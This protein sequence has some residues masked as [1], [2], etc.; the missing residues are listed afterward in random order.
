MQ[1]R[2]AER[3]AIVFDEA[4]AF[5]MTFNGDR[6]ARRV[7]AH[8][9]DPDRATARTDIPQQF[10]WRR[11]KSRKRD[12]A[13]I[14]LGQ[15]AVVAKRVVGQTR[16]KRQPRRA[17]SGTA[18]QRNQVQCRHRFARPRVGAATETAFPLAAEVLQH[19]H[20]GRAEAA[21]S[22]QCSQCSGGGAIGAQD[23]EP[24]ASVQMDVQRGKRPTHQRDHRHILQR[25]PEARRRQRQRRRCGQ[26]AH[27]TGRQL[28]GKCRPHAEQHRI[29]ACEHANRRVALG[30]HRGD[31][32][33]TRPCF[34]PRRETRG[35]HRQMPLA[36]EYHG[37]VEQ[38]APCRAPQTGKAV[39]A[40]AHHGQPCRHESIL[41]LDLKL[42]AAARQSRPQ[43]RCAIRKKA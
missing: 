3:V 39:I 9:F 14:A 8:P 41:I 38:R 12:G 19:D 20:A 4:L 16:R 30:Q 25:P 36:A 6:P 23:E 28:T 15:L 22:K 21:R 18:F 17:V 34:A 31:I 42:T 43:H 40:D 1:T 29:A 27:F 11:R 32:E 7:R 35:Q 2:H 24:R 37:R 33:G 5:R 13:D 26:H 10:A